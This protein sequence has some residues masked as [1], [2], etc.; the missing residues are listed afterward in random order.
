VWITLKGWYISL[1]HI[2]DTSAH[3]HAYTYTHA[4][5][6]ARS[7]THSHKA[8]SHE[9]ALDGLAVVIDCLDLIYLQIGMH[10]DSGTDTDKDTDSDAH[11]HIEI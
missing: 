5:A 6:H 8:L 4:H 9:L 1:A 7:H 10:T 11:I 3:I 2:T